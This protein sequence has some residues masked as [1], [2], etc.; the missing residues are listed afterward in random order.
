LDLSDW[1]SRAAGALTLPS[2][3]AFAP[4]EYTAR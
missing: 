1:V 2:P 4:S 3:A